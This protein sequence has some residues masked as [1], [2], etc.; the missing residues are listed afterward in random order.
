MALEYRFALFVL[1]VCIET[2]AII[3]AMFNKITQGELRFFNK[4][5][6]RETPPENVTQA[7]TPKH[8]AS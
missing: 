1:Q 7:H 5:S 6:W 4:D 8:L 2:S 3:A